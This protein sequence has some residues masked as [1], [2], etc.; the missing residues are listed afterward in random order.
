MNHDEA[1]KVA[2]ACAVAGYPATNRNVLI[3]AMSVLQRAS[4]ESK[5]FTED[6]YTRLR[7]SIQ[8]IASWMLVVDGYTDLSTHMKASDLWINLVGSKA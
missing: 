1:M 5:N 6:E 7:V 8:V 2:E 4:M 3:N